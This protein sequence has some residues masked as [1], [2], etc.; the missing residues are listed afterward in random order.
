MKHSWLL[1][2]MLLGIIFL[3]AI[4]E[5]GCFLGLLPI[6]VHTTQPHHGIRHYLQF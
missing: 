5:P 1:V 2:F 4:P 3:G 6:Q